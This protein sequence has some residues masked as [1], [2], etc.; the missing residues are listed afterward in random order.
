MRLK[1]TKKLVRLVVI[2]TVKRIIYYFLGFKLQF[3]VRFVS[4]RSDLEQN[5]KQVVDNLITG[6]EYSERLRC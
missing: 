6:V 1:S 4:Q 2:V 3:G 5:E